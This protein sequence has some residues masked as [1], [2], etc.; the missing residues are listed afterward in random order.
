MRRHIRRNVFESNSSSVHT[1][2]LTGVEREPNKLALDKNGYIHIDYSTFDSRYDVYSSQYEKLSYL[3]TLCYYCTN[4]DIEETCST[5]Q[6]KALEK[7][8]ME[9]TGC[10]GIVIDAEDQP[11]IDHQSLPWYGE[12]EFLDIYD[13]DAV[14]DFVFNKYASLETSRD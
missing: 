13:K 1:L 3:A 10:K 6:F 5:S 9:Y 2:V 7:A 8:V 4:Y 11:Y 14:I 12:I